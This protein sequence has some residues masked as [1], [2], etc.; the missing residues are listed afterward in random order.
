MGNLFDTVRASILIG[1]LI[2]IPGCVTWSTYPSQKMTDRM[3]NPSNEP[4][5]T[6]MTKAIHFAYS[7]YGSGE[8]DFAINLPEGVSHEIYTRVIR[9]LEIGHPMTDPNETTYHVLE[10]RI[11]GLEAEVDLLY[12]RQGSIYEMVTLS[13]RRRL[14]EGWT[15]LT[16]RL[17]RVH[18]DRPQPNYV[19]PAPNVLPNPNRSSEAE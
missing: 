11:R 18:V 12:P 19:P 17:R 13:F 14:V 9:K 15:V 2:V 10:I 5:P 16:S 1:I 6:L 4:T 3:T 7:H 8:E